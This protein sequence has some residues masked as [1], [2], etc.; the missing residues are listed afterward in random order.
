M[1]RLLHM[2]IGSAQIDGLIMRLSHPKS[3]ISLFINRL[4]KE[5]IVVLLITKG[6]Q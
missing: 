6:E 5:A 3:V 1:F 4:A 2:Q